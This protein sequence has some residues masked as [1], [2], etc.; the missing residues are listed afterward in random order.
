[1]KV[2]QE[3]EVNETSLFKIMFWINETKNY[4]KSENQDVANHKGCTFEH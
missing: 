3:L 2:N 4:T 1:M